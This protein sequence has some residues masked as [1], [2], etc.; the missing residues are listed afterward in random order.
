[1]RTVALK[2][3]RFDGPAPDRLRRVQRFQREARTAARIW[4]PHVC[5][6]YDVGEQ[7]GQPFVVMPF[8]EGQSLA[9][10]LASKGRFEEV[11]AAVA[12]VLQVCDAL[13]AVH[14]H[15]VIHRDLKD[16]NILLD[17]GGRAI[18]TDFGLARPENDA[19]HL[20]SEGVILGTPSFM[21]PEVAAGRTGE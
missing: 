9:E 8:I 17:S 16:G 18:L 15:G 12:L 10:R 7:D 3:P 13:E 5:P 1:D 6:I 11:L 19:E 2:L 20:T 21:A 14:G 4:H